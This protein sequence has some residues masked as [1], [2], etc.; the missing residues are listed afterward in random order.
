[1]LIEG[2]LTITLLTTNS[3]NGSLNIDV[4]E[5]DKENVNKDL[6]QYDT[7]LFD[8]DSK[9][10]NKHIKEKQKGKEQNIKNNIFQNQMGRPTRLNETKNI[11]F[12]SSEGSDKGSKSEKKPYVQNKQE[13]NIWEYI[14]LSIGAILTVGVVIFSVKRGRHR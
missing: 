13:Q 6:E 2:L 14:L 7:T 9:S 5:E 12:A 10:V 1:M 3:P 11:L 8:K 4:Q